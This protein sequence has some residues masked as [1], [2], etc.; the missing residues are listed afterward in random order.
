QNDDG[1][2]AN[3]SVDDVTVAEGAGG[4]FTV[5][6]QHPVLDVVS[7]NWTLKDG[8]ALAGSD[9][10]AASGVVAFAPNSP[11]PATINF[12]VS[13][14]TLHEANEAFTVELSNPVN[15]VLQKGTGTATITDDDAAPAVS[16][17]PTKAVAEGNSGNT[18]ATLDVT[19]SAVSGVPAQV[20]F[21]SADGTATSGTDYTADANS[22][23]TFAPGETTKQ[24][25]V[26][27]VGDTLFEDDETFTVTLASPSGASLG[28]AVATVTVTNDDAMPVAHIDNP[29]APVVE[30]AT[31][32]NQAPASFAVK[33]D[34]P[35]G[36]S[37][38]VKYVTADGTALFPGDYVAVA[39]GTVTIPAGAQA[40]AAVVQVKADNVANEVPDETFTVTI[41]NPTAATTDPSHVTAT[42][43]ITDNTATS[44]PHV[45][46]NTAPVSVQEGNSGTATNTISVSL[47]PAQAG[48]VTVAY[49][50]ADG[51]AAAPG[52]Y[53][54]VTRG[55][56]SFAAGE[57]SKS[58]SVS[59]VG[60]TID[61][62][63]ETFSVSLISDGS[64]PTGTPTP[65]VSPGSTTVTI[66][67]DD[68]PALSVAP[69]AVAEGDSGTRPAN[70]KVSLSA[71]SLQTVTVDYGTSDGT[72]SAPSD[73]TTTSG[74][75]TFNLGE[76]TKTVP[77]PVVGDTRDEPDQDFKFGLSNPVN[78]TIGR[79]LA[80]GVI[81]DDDQPV[82]AV[83]AGVSTPGAA[84]TVR[85][86]DD[87]VTPMVFTLT[88]NA[89]TTRE[90]SLA[91][92]TA[93]GTARAG[94]DY[95]PVSGQLTFAPGETTKTVVVP[96][97]GDV[98]K[99]VDETFGLRLSGPV[100]VTISGDGVGTI[101][102]DDRP[103]YSLV[104]SD[105]GLFAFGNAGFYG[106]TGNIVLNQPIVG[107][108]VT[109]SGRGYWL[110]ATDGGIFSFGD[111]RFFGSTGAL[112]LVK[113]IVGMAA[114]PSGGGYWL[115]ASDGGIFS[116]GDARF[117]GSTGAITLNKPIVG[118]AATPSGAGYWLVA[119]D[120]GIFSFGDARVFGS[121]GAIK[122][123]K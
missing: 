72:A 52:D 33:L 54:P 98:R 74:T 4:H 114:T 90:S 7:V 105:G 107:S 17:E 49:S 6:L 76:T 84:P 24:I 5:S 109:P 29:T 87:G 10:A 59:A 25:Q 78:A 112:K 27:A 18:K 32:G 116:F 13:Q 66:R 42:G 55:T 104:A 23:L 34:R 38:T 75:L 58:I 65:T 113:P 41:S 123:N 119:T 22:T 120:G 117:F 14:D 73:Y 95:L 47:T 39:N 56:V 20:N 111:A 8:T 12:S 60:D 122:L 77:V 108:A 70:F 15:A 61:E 46:I 2:P 71:A 88:L 31:A 30:P 44:T 80:S 86:G 81:L 64:S 26:S 121:T 102:D 89:A 67:D 110:V 16:I 1:P 82:V 79:G 85:E 51:T 37:V 57:T 118:M 99:E 69:V 21:A 83:V 50:T 63:D 11:G 53:V 106:S 35:S 96:V 94:V 62:A 9:Y 45:A 97:V 19:L 91:Y 100:N 3:I 48:P 40:A 92:T 101:L 28:G 68:G 43:A 115:V 93:D 103:G 36:K